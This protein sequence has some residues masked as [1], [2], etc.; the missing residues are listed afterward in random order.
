MRSFLKP[1]CLKA[2]VIFFLLFS[3]NS[4]FSQGVDSHWWNGQGYL[5]DFRTSPPTVS[6]GLTSGGAFEATATWS[7][8]I[9]GDLIFYVDDGDVYDNTG[10]II[11]N[12]DNL[13]TNGTRTQMATVMPVPGTNARQIYIIHGNG[14]DELNDGT[15]YYSIVNVDTMAVT[16]KNVTFISGASEAI[17]GTN[18]GDKCGGWIAAIAN[19]NSGCTTNCNASIFL[20]EV[21]DGNELTPARANNPDLQVSIPPQLARRGER[22][23]IRF[24]RQNDLIAIA[25]EFGGVYYASFDPD[26]GNIGTWTHVPR[27]TT[28]LTDSGYSLDFSPDGTRLFYSHENFTGAFAWQ[29]DLYMHIIGDVDSERIENETLGSWAGIAL[30]PDDNLYLSDSGSGNIYYLTNPNT[31]TAAANANF[32]FIDISASAT[33][34]GFDVQGFNFSQQVVFFDTCIIDQDGDGI[35]DES[36]NCPTIPNADQ[37]DADGDGVGDVCDLDDDNDGILDTEESNCTTV[38]DASSAEIIADAGVPNNQRFRINDGLLTPDQGT[39]IDNINEY[40]I[41]D[42]NGAGVNQDLPLG[43]TISIYIWES[44]NNNKRLRVAQLPNAT[45]DLGN[46]VNEFFIS[47][48][49]VFGVTQFDYTL[50][51]DTQFIQIEMDQDTNGRFE[52]IEV[53]VRAHQICTDIDTDT[54]GTVDRLDLDSDGDGCFDALEGAENILV[55]QIDASGVIT[56]GVDSDGVP[57]LAT[58]GQGLGSSQDFAT[59]DAQCDDDGDGVINANDI[60]N[61]FD[62]TAD[63]DV[64]NVPDNCDLDNDNDGILDSNE[65]LNCSSTLNVGVAVGN[66]TTDTFINNM[67]THDGVNVDLTTSLTN[68]SLTQ[69]QVQDATTLRVQGT[70]ADDGAG[71]S[72]VYIFTFSEPVANVKFRWTGIDQGD[73]VTVTSTGPNGANDI[74]LAGFANPVSTINSDYDGTNVGDPNTGG[75]LFD[76]TNNSSTSPTITS[77]INGGDANQSYSDVIINGLVSS[78]QITTRKARQDNNVANTGTLTFTFTNFEYCTYDDT[79]ADGT[80]NHLDLDSDGDACNDVVES[81]GVDTNNDGILDG[82]GFNSTGQVT[83]GTGGYNGLSATGGEYIAVETSVNATALV[84]QIIPI[85]IGTSFTVTSVTASSATSFS[86][87]TPNYGTPGNANAGINYQWY[88]GD[89]SSGGTPIAASNTNYSGETSDTLTI[90]DVTGLNNTEYFLVVGHN[91]NVCTNIVNS[92]TLFVDTTDSDGDDIGD[93]AD[94]DD[95]N[96]GILD[97][98]ELAACSGELTYEYYDGTPS[99]LTVDNIPTTGAGFTGTVASLDV[100]DLVIN[101]L[102]EVNDSYGLRYKGFLNI[103]NAGNYNFY[104][105][106]DDGSKLFI[107]GVEVVDNDGDHGVI[108]RT[109]SRFLSVGLHEIEILFYENAGGE[110]LDFEYELSG[111]ITRQD[112]PFASLFC[113]LDTDGDGSPNHLD[114]DSDD[115]GCFDAIEAD[116]NVTIAQVTGGG[117]IS[118]AVDADGVPVLVNSGGAADVGGDQGQGTTANVILSNAAN[119]G[120]LSG[121][122]SVCTSATVTITTD[123]DSG[124]SWSSSNTSVATVDSSGVVT[125]VSAG[126]VTITY[127]VPSAGGCADDSSTINL[128]VNASPIAPVV[129]PV[130]YC[131]GDTASALTATGSN[132]LWYTNATGGIGSATAPTPVTSSAGTT[133]YYVSQTNGS[134]CESPRAELVVTVYQRPLADNP[135]DV[136]ACDSYTLPALTNGGYFT[137][138]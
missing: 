87:G 94:L 89:P 34:N 27:T 42:L 13:L 2:S 12:G 129:S 104:L 116:E 49:D 46:G 126:S 99:G 17:F 83:G 107:N 35:I 69:L 124:G 133:S 77:F 92:A 21:E 120:T 117:S 66:Y 113:N 7:D 137:T 118:G 56:G 80:P 30:G 121:G 15:G 23:S 9:T 39:P 18:N 123:G 10:T 134:G 90:V 36:D 111:V 29:S 8:P 95:D 33:C 47:T 24:N 103:S 55:S 32:T 63:I 93:A 73:K 28:T 72:V 1:N 132:L 68:A 58:S 65:G 5:M 57:N 4:L 108:T 136:E 91:S 60:C 112:V 101:V 40:I 102:G 52:F 6:C 82:S 41:L 38:P 71:D 114:T 48:A 3:F 100:D 119:A 53:I 81:G 110:S 130:E 128:T 20:W 74:L 31:T 84:D 43:T 22:A 50:T 135:S 109:G 45:P 115:D 67:Y 86:S 78:F 11:T 64:D 16:T 59:T 79:D 76:I 54:D 75:V 25:V 62:D 51:A 127:T 106:S 37:A 105:S 14:S 19:D 131:T 122:P 70:G 98:D 61:G 88:I 44:N 85:G 97:T 138:T 125:G 26:T 96:D